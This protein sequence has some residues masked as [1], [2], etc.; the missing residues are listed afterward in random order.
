MN[1]IMNTKS[2]VCHE[3]FCQNNQG[4]TDAYRRIVASYYGCAVATCKDLMSRNA[5]NR[6]GGVNVAISAEAS[7]IEERYASLFTLEEVATAKSRLNRA[8]YNVAE[9]ATRESSFDCPIHP[10]AD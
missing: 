7:V 6:F 4:A 5:T 1:C 10:Q 2:C 9:R 3:H 8:G